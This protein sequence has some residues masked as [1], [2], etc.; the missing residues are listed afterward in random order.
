MVGGGWGWRG[1]QQKHEWRVEEAAGGKKRKNRKKNCNPKNT[2]IDHLA[3][4]PATRQCPIQTAQKGLRDSLTTNLGRLLQAQRLHFK[5]SKVCQEFMVSTN[6]NINTGA[7]VF[8]FLSF[9]M[10]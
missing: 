5:W 10:Q 6:V 2:F 7:S 3:L 8:F 9:V 4:V 1:A